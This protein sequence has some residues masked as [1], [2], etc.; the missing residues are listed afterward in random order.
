MVRAMKDVVKQV[1]AIDTAFTRLKMVT[2]ASDEQ[3]SK[4][5]STYISLARE[6]K[7]SL[8]TVTDA[9]EAW[10]RT[11]MN[12]K[13]ANDA[14]QASIVLSTVAFMDGATAT[15][16]L[17]AAQKA[18]GLE[19]K[20]LM[21]VVDKLAILDSNAATTAADL[22]EALSMSASSAGLAG[23]ELDK[24]L[25]ILATTSETTQQSA[26]NIGNAWKTI[27]A[28]LQQVKLGSAMD[29]EGQDISNVDKLLKEYNIDLL[30]ETD[31]LENMEGLLD[32]LGERWKN[33]TAMQKSEIATIVAGVR[34]RDK[35]IAALNN[36]DRVMELT[37]KQAEEEGAAQKK[38]Q[39]YMESTQAKIDN[40][41]TA[42]TELADATLQSEWIEWFVTLGTKVLD[43]GKKAGGLVPV[44][45]ELAGAFALLKGGIAGIAGGLVVGAVAVYQL[46]TYFGSRYQEV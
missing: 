11:G 17:V 33:Y 37:T 24:Y 15:Q 20:D 1:I 28:R 12:A 38:M 26:S 25:A 18:Y 6:M 13:D 31:N 42:W 7:V 34:Q 21:G 5:K 19:A 3:L 32:T 23:I 14:L 36:Y 43:F 27:L 16:Y 30:K 8:S 35:L 40:L 39:D 41:K 22:G 4:M 29:E 46:T 45:I 2:Q 44:V 10:L 9:A